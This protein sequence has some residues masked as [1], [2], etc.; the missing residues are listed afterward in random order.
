[1]STLKGW[2]DSHGGVILAIIHEAGSIERYR[3]NSVGWGLM[4]SE[5]VTKLGVFELA[6][7]CQ[8]T[9]VG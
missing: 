9:M 7:C 6:G 3:V 4:E 1:M 5:V 2:V 8:L